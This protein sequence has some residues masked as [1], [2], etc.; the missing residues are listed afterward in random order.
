MSG[1]KVWLVVTSDT[2][3]P[4]ASAARCGGA[5][6]YSSV[7]ETGSCAPSARPSMNETGMSTTKLCASGSAA[8][9][10][11][12]TPSEMSSTCQPVKAR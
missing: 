10:T 1:R 6:S 8:R 2:R 7:I 9:L 4:N 5:V 12:P 3:S 11:P